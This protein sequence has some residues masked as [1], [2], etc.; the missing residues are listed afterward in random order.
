MLPCIQHAIRLSAASSRGG[1]FS[2]TRMPALVARFQSTGQKSFKEIADAEEA[3]RRRSIAYYS[4][5]AVVICVG[6][7]YAAV[8]LYRLFCQVSLDKSKL[9]NERRHNS[10]RNRFDC[11]RPATE[12]PSTPHKIHPKLHKCDELKI[13]Y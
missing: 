7:T 3:L 9:R 4:I 1:V 12:A 8:P 6:L 10:I 11:S 5:S 13:P 2:I